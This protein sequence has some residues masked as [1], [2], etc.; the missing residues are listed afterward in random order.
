MLVGGARPPRQNR[1]RRKSPIHEMKIL[2]TVT[3]VFL[4]AG[5]AHRAPTELVPVRAV[6]VDFMQGAMHAQ[7]TDGVNFWCEWCDAVTFKI[8][9][10]PEWRGRKLVV[11]FTTDTATDS[12]P[13]AVGKT[14][15]LSD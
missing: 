12:L 4:L 13:N 14:L 15:S 9:S 11:H 8:E 5:C 2:H 7:R 3:A 10:P 6:V 1:G